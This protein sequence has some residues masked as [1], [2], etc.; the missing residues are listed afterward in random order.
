VQALVQAVRTGPLAARL[1]LLPVCSGLAEA[2][3]R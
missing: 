1:A 2:P 3:V